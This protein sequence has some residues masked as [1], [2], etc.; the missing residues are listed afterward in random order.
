MLYNISQMPIEFFI[1]YLRKSRSD[2]PSMSVEEVLSRHEQQLQEFAVE[3]FGCKIPEENIFREVVSGETIADRPVM[4]EVMKLLETGTK[5]GVLVIEPQ[6]LSRGDLEDCGKVI[7]VFRYTNTLVITPPKTYNL[8]DEY[9]RKF[10]EMELTRGNDYL[11]YTKKILNRGR[12]ASVKQGNFIASVAPY[13][14]KKVKKGSG[15]D[16]CHTLEIIPEQADTVRLMFKLYLEGNGFTNIAKHLD[17]I[18]AKPLKS[19]IWSPAAISDMLENPVYVGMVRWNYFKTVKK[20]VDGQIVKSRPINR[21]P[22]DW[23]M[24]K[25]KHT[26]IIDQATFDDAIQRRGQSPKVKRGKELR[27]PFAGLLFCGTCGKAMSLKIYK[28]KKV[29]GELLTEMMLC[30]KQSWCKTKSVKYDDFSD[31][32]IETLERTIADFELKLQNDDVDSADLHKNIIM[33]LEMDLKKLKDK[34]IRQKDA[35]EDG[36]YTKEEYSSRNAKLQEELAKTMEALCVAKDSV[37]PSIDYQ[38]KIVRFTDCLTALKDPNVPAS[39]KNML[40]KA[41]IEKIVYINNMES[42]PGIGRWS[43]N[44]FNLDIFLRL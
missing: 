38:E 20:I 42:K 32:V 29:K 15:K 22:S 44:I 41:C 31:R 10:F 34:D 18:G 36:I 39:E 30:N 17:S 16:A 3:T 13:G 25:G 7:N 4:K 33:N 26:A 2:D 23:F 21:D 8:S 6:R 40:L 5:K 28:Q 19:D 37:P 11:E 12:I 1:I 27:N 43:E 9:D 24:V 14:Y 35:Y